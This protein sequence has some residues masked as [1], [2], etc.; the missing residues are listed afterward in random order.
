MCEELFDALKW[1]IVCLGWKEQESTL[2]SYSQ[3]RDSGAYEI[4][5]IFEQLFYHGLLSSFEA[6]PSQ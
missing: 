3:V 1:A 4:A 5:R 6:C 2:N